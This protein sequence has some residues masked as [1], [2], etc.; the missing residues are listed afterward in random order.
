M[1]ALPDTGVL[2]EM[3][4]NLLGIEEP[5]WSPRSIVLDRIAPLPS[6]PLGR[7][8]GG[9]RRFET[10]ACLKRIRVTWGWRQFLFL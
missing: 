6:G 7:Q 10:R 8:M 3:L 2:L 1:L 4:T 9:K 5:L